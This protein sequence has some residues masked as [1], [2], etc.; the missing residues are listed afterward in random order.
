MVSIGE[1]RFSYTCLFQL[2][3]TS[4]IFCFTSVSARYNLQTIPNAAAMLLCRS[5]RHNSY[6][7]VLTLASCEILDS[8]EDFNNNLS[9]ITERFMPVHVAKH[10]SF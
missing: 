9:S 2:F 10:L 3:L 4:A 5:N 8:F 6:F 1:L 7:Y